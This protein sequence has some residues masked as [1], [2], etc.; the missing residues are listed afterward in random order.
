[1]DL[2]CQAALRQI[3]AFPIDKKFKFKIAHAT[4][5]LREK[6]MRIFLFVLTSLSSWVWANPSSFTQLRDEA[7][8]VGANFSQGLDGCSYKSEGTRNELWISIQSAYGRYKSVRIP[9]E[10]EV[11]FEEYLLD[12]KI[13]HL[14]RIENN[15]NYVVKYTSALTIASVAIASNGTSVSCDLI[16]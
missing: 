14:Y 1:M 15:L 7:L 11:S 5:L 4:V 6:C 16:K 8:L 9:H 10:A 13:T 2:V 12:G 3:C